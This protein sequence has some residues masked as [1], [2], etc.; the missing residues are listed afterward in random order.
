MMVGLPG[1]WD[2]TDEQAQKLREYLLRGG[3]L[4][5][6]SFFGTPRVGGIHGRHAARVPDRPIVDLSPDH[7]VFH[8]VYDLDPA[9]RRC[10]T[11]TRYRAA[12]LIAR[13][14]RCLTG[15]ASSTT[16]GG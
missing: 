13:T 6:D 5:C 12:C 14:G 1:M 4:L 16:M 9:R 2:L 10:R 7:P 8:T 11:G 15:A 3:F